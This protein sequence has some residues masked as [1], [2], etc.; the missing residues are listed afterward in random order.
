M[1]DTAIYGEGWA[2]ELDLLFAA[3]PPKIR[4]AARRLP[5]H[6]DLL[7]VVLEAGISMSGDD[8]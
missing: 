4:D 8:V 1:S 5:S 6:R 2:T 3:L 7:E